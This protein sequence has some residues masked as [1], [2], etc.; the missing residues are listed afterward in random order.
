MPIDNIKNFDKSSLEW[1]EV[2]GTC[3]SK[4]V[5][6]LRQI[7][8]GIANGKQTAQ[9]CKEAGITEQIYYQ[10]RMEYGGL[11]V[12]QAKRLE[13]MEQ[14]NAKLKRLVAELRLDMTQEIRAIRHSQFCE[15]STAHPRNECCGR[16]AGY[17]KV[18]IRKIPNMTKRPAIIRQSR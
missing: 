5:Y 15:C 10:W 16:V 9:S 13:D 3:R 2:R 6:M 12:N 14:E 8:M 11:Q 4:V 7:E 18:T 1:D 17:T